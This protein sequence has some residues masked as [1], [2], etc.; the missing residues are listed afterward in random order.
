MEINTQKSNKPSE[1][2]EYFYL[3]KY[4]LKLGYNDNNEI[5]I[6]CYNTELL[7]GITYESKFN[8]NEYKKMNDIQETIINIKDIYNLIRKN[9][10]DGYYQIDIKN[11]S[12]IDFEIK[13]IS[14]LKLI[15][16]NSNIINNEYLYVISNEIRNLKNNF[17]NEI[18]LLKEEN[19]SIKN[20]LN[21]LKNLIKNLQNNNNNNNNIIK[22]K[23]EINN[24][25]NEIIIEKEKEKEKNKN[26]QNEENILTI[27]EF[28]KKFMTDIENKDITELELGYKNL[29]NDIL[30]LANIDF[31]QLIK[32]DLGSNNISNINIL[33]KLKYNKLQILY[34][35]NNLISDIN[36]F[37][38][39][40]FPLIEEID[41]SKNSISDINVLSKVKFN[42]LKELYLCDNNIKNIDVF[43]NVN[44]KGIQKLNLTKNKIEDINV[45][46]KIN[47][48]QLK[49]LYLKNNNIDLK[50]N[51]NLINDLKSKIIDFNI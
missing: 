47:F 48:T 29:G 23:N 34:L 21:E 24:K 51:E 4:Y 3:G 11:N 33:S 50:T 37:A 26:N 14:K 27:N 46:T 35:D 8:I 22:D 10:N 41:L 32:L 19:Y 6:N 30:Y 7:D 31:N 40:N 39:V 9:I 43:K 38:D 45:F 36:V 28:N 5:I 25:T 18:K 44:F 1:Y 16:N 13:G 15:K 12:E 17:N 42:E 20:E 2:N 49:L